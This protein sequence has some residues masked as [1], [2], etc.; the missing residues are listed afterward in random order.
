[1]MVPAASARFWARELWS[2]SAVS[3]ALALF[4]AFFGLLLSYP[5]DV[6]S[7]P[8]IILVAG[9]VYAGSVVLGPRDSLRA[10]YFRGV[11]ARGARAAH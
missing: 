1:M 7:G 10:L 11:S 8:A 6:P 9:L 5:L 2:L 4:S 3:S